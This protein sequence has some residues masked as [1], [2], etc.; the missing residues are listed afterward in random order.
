MPKK[1]LDEFDKHISETGK[2]NRSD[3]LRSL[4]RRYMAEERWNGGEGEIYGTVTIVYDHHSMNL[5]ETIMEMQHE[6]ADV[7]VCTQHVHINHDTCLECVIMR[8]EV[9]KVRDFFESLD[10]IR[11]IRSLE[12]VIIPAV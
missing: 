1:L 7:I 10:K 8:G 4:V 2:G 3:A 5:S 6:H 11:G 12:T 9:A